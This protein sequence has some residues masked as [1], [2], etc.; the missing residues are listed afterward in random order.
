MEV[1]KIPNGITNRQR[2]TPLP[3]I[4]NGTETIVSAYPSQ[5]IMAVFSP[6]FMT[7]YM[8]FH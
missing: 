3:I 1:W 7:I 2:I 5:H 4:Y 6:I 8:P